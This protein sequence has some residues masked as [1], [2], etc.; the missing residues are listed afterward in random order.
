MDR[1]ALL[2]C[3]EAEIKRLSG[4]VDID[5]R[6]TCHYQLMEQHYKGRPFFY[7][8]VLK[9]DR[10]LVVLSMLAHYYCNS[11]PSL[12]RV[13]EFCER[14]G[15]LSKNS[16]E[17]YFS[18]FLISGYMDVGD[19]PED[20]RLRVFKPSLRAMAETIKVLSA[21]YFPTM[22][23]LEAED[24][25]RRLDSRTVQAYFKG[26]NKVLEA[27]LT[28]DTLVPESRWLMNRDGGHML[29]LAFFSDA[30]KGPRTSAGSY[31]VSTYAQLSSRLSVSSTHL[32]R[33][34]REGEKKGYFKAC[35]SGL[36]ITECF[37]TLVRR[38]MLV[39][40]AI[41]Q[42]CIRLGED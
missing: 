41:T 28:L 1:T 10:F 14:R 26:F 16:L 8:S 15:Y 23:L 40:F 17:S 11:F 21:Y 37:M 24:N 25:E 32:I 9:Y 5:A 20:R 33:L 34:V 12:S 7:K 39:S 22:G 18:F 29:M 13:K 3:L 2:D 6:I 4:C 30:L 42:V 31:K 35:K 36:E 19:H 38:M 27:N